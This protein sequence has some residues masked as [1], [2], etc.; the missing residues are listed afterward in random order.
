MS[1]RRLAS[2]SC[3]YTREKQEVAF[4]WLERE[5]ERDFGWAMKDNRV[6]PLC[7]QERVQQNSVGW[8]ARLGSPRGVEDT[9]KNSI[10]GLFDEREI[11]CSSR[12]HGWQ[13]GSFIRRQFGIQNDT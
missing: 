4:D 5:A 1:M 8:K 9:K 12:P 3:F 7:T 2:E 6:E 13:W 11:T 10:H